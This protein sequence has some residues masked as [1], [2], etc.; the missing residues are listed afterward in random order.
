MKVLVFG[1]TS[2]IAQA[3]IRKLIDQYSGEL[4]IAIV[5]RTPQK[6]ESVR[7]D[8]VAR[9][10]QCIYS[11][12]A[13]LSNMDDALA[14]TKSILEELG[15]FDLVFVAHGFLPNQEQITSNEIL[16][17]ENFRVNALSYILIMSAVSR[18][19]TSH[20]T[21]TI[22][23]L[24]SVAGE[25]GRASNYAYGSAK[26]AVTLFAQGLRNSLHGSGVRVLTVKPG[27]VDT[28]MTSE[29]ENKGPLW[30]TP[31]KVADCICSALDKGKDTVYAPWY[32]RYVMLIIRLIPESIFKRLSL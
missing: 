20:G 23:L 32:W 13:D 6:I 30:S 8:I 17:M 3:T 12:T 24:S 27:L 15:S 2:A 29:F 22:V 31:E 1:A 19:M 25:R 28:P 26:G 5:G 21:G 11:T 14:L 7:S 4:E 16:Q 9:G 10:A 18:D